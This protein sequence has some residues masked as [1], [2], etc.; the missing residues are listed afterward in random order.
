METT[1]LLRLLWAQLFVLCLVRAQDCIPD[2]FVKSEFEQ[3]AVLNNRLYFY[4]GQALYNCT[5]GLPTWLPYPGLRYVNLSDENRT[6]H[7]L[8]VPD[9]VP[10][11]AMGALWSDNR[12]R[13]FLFG[14]RTQS[15][16]NMAAQNPPPFR[17]ARGASASVPETRKAYWMGGGY[18]DQRTGGGLVYLPYGKKGAL[19]LMGG[20]LCA[21]E[22][23]H[24][25]PGYHPLAQVSIYDLASERIYSQGT[26]SGNG[27]APVIGWVLPEGRADFCMVTVPSYDETVHAIYVWGG[28][29]GPDGAVNDSV[30]VLL[31]PQFVWVEVY[32]G[33]YGRFGTTCQVTHERFMMFSGG[34]QQFG[35]NMGVLDLTTI[36]NGYWNGWVEHWQDLTDGQRYPAVE[37]WFRYNPRFS[38]YY[39]GGILKSLAAK[40]YTD[41]S[42]ADIHRPFSGWSHPELKL[43][44][45]PSNHTRPNPFRTKDYLKAAKM[46]PVLLAVPFVM[47]A[48]QY[49]YSLVQFKRGGYQQVATNIVLITWRLFVTRYLYLTF[50]ALSS[51][52]LL[53]IVELLYQHS[54]NPA[55]EPGQRTMHVSGSEPSPSGYYP[56]TMSRPRLGLFAYCDSESTNRKDMRGTSSYLGIGT[57]FLWNYLPAILTILYG[58]SW[59]QC[60]TEVERI[61]PYYHLFNNKQRA[62]N[63][64]N[65]DYHTFWAPLR[66]WQALKYRQW[67]CVL[68]STA[69]IIAFAV[70]PNLLNNVFSLEKRDGGTYRDLVDFD[71]NV[72]GVGYSARVAVMDRT[73]ARA[74]EVVLGVNMLG[75]VTLMV[76]FW[77]RDR[78]SKGSGLHK[79][80]KGMERLMELTEDSKL[81]G[82]TSFTNGTGLRCLLTPPGGLQDFANGPQ[83]PNLDE[84]ARH[85]RCW[86]KDQNGSFRLRFECDH[87]PA[88]VPSKRLRP[89]KPL[90]QRTTSW[91]AKIQAVLDRTGLILHQQ[92]F[93]LNP[94]PLASLLAIILTILGGT[95]WILASHLKAVKS[96]DNATPIPS[97]LYLVIGVLVKASLPLF[98]FRP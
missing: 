57:Y 97:V 59:Q 82:V 20:S 50:I 77:W 38:A 55:F 39:L 31:V 43:I 83:D 65:V 16:E 35:S 30:W 9:E 18:G 93:I 98:P 28:M 37:P 33:L 68:S 66:L 63:T 92:P 70:I 27:D 17:L 46:T 7:T 90:V 19:I 47:Y 2:G 22:D 94:L 80:P 78:T 54:V 95:I 23:C 34:V 91:W 13:L 8:N 85:H 1:S 3:S 52:S 40:E 74:L 29:I 14:G 60:D 61:E 4:G 44:F 10:K 6:L 89:L 51:L 49:L 75:A 25:V 87:K 26:I 72:D 48:A 76:I 12:D 41:E 69:Y 81:M 62:G 53:V 58:Y 5:G 36:S 32:N 73:L 79:A 45:S 56:T 71:N 84:W 88:Q 64:L 86:T 21:S 11:V 15:W 96:Q 42:P 67:T 24:P